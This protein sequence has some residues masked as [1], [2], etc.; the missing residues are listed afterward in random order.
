[1]SEELKCNDNCP[2]GAAWAGLVI[3]IIALIM[4]IIVYV[5]YFTERSEFLKDADVVWTPVVI[6]STDKTVDGENFTLYQVPSTF[7]A[8]DTITLNSPTGGAKV[9]EWFSITNLN[10]KAVKIVPGSGVDFQSFP[11][12]KTTGVPTTTNGTGVPTTTTNGPLTSSDLAG[13]HSWLLVWLSS[14]S[15]LNLVPGG[16]TQS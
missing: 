11:T 8:G 12:T 9:G 5:F 13:K 1:M 2:S 16:V 10:D 15:V 4:I 3:A 14:S 7:P 6:S